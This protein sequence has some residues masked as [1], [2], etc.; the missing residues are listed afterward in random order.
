MVLPA[1]LTSTVEIM[2]L[3][4]VDHITISPAFL[5]DLSEIPASSLT[6]KS[7]FDEKPTS[8]K[9]YPQMTFETDEAGF[10]KAFKERERGEG[11]RKLT[12]VNRTAQGVLTKCTDDCRL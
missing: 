7:L 8:C 5:Q 3:A 6:T 10:Q 11:V 1:S 12:E 2:E 9:S 4:G